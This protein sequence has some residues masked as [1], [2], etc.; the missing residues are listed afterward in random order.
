MDEK[1]FYCE[2]FSQVHSSVVINEEFLQKKH[3]RLPKGVVLLAA[4]VALLAGLSTV[5]VATDWFGLHQL[6]LPHQQQVTMPIDPS[7]GEQAVETVD[8]ISLAGYMDTPE[9]KATAEWR[10]FLNGYDS[11]GAIIAAIG[12]NPTGFEEKYSMY[13]VYTQEMADK[14]EEIV[15]RYDLKLHTEMAWISEQQNLCAQVGGDFLGWN[16]TAYGIYIYEDGTFKFDGEAALEGY[17]TVDYQ[18]MRLVKGSFTDLVLNIGDA[19]DYRQWQYE[20]ASGA[21]VTLA[22]SGRQG[23]I[24]LD[25]GDAF[26]SVNVL[27]GEETPEDDIFSSGP[28]F[29]ENLEALADSFD[30]TVLQP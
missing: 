13:Q 28:F 3:R 30:F 9:G 24:F 20:T 21:S 1:Q 17:G 5:A 23:L 16:N 6:L 11:D 22:L 2:T 27:A 14:L 12:N 8:M 4:V 26:V 18:F 10:D 25:T 29:A 7:T 15:E 19:A